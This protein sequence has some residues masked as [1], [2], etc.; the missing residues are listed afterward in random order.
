MLHGGGNTSVKIRERNIVGDEEGILYVKG[1]G[2]DLVFIKETGFSPVRLAHLRKLA[3][4]ETLSDPQLV[5]EFTAHM[6]RAAASPPSLE[7]I[8]HVLLR[9]STSTTPMPTLCSR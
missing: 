6:T 2:S 7:A 5:N 4:L 3:Q 1:S 9:I 8:L